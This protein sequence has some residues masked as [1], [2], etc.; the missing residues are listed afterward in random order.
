MNSWD[1]EKIK[2]LKDEVTNE[3]NSRIEKSK[4]DIIDSFV[5]YYGEKYRN[6]I[7]DIFNETAFVYYVNDITIF[8]L[9]EKFIKGQ[10]KDE[11][12]LRIIPYMTYTFVNDLYRKE[13]NA[14]NFY[15]VGSNRLFGV[16]GENVHF[17]E[18]MMLYC[19]G[20]VNRDK[21][22]NPYEFNYLVNKKIQ[23]IIALPIFSVSD[24][25]FFH[26]LNHAVTSG[27]IIDGD[28]VI[29]KCG[30][31]S[32]TE[33]NE[34]MEMVNSLQCKEILKFFKSKNNKTIFN[35]Y[36]HEEI[37]SAYESKEME[38][39]E[40]FKKYEIELKEI[41][42]EKKKFNVGID[43]LFYKNVKK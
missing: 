35:N 30:I 36:L 4:R 16:S 33:N 37:Y 42:I 41:S 19:L 5:E 39:I 10:I 3:F 21:N 34:L 20:L 8:G 29:I 9:K 40:T 31:N 14:D 23:R 1:S 2:L 27:L 12:V 26:E 17:D 15:T 11:E 24:E 28:N 6:E 13:I 32:E 7:T 22:I 38:Y 43:K 18:K 25:A